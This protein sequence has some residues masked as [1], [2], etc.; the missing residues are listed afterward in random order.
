VEQK[1]ESTIAINNIA[2]MKYDYGVE[3]ATRNDDD[4]KT[5]NKHSTLG[6]GVVPRQE[7]RNDAK[8]AV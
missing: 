5:A 7:A 4:M 1:F 8:L 3:I 2:A 6:A